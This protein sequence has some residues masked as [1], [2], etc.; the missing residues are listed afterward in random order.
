[1]AQTFEIT[2][3]EDDILD[4]LDDDDERISSIMFSEDRPSVSLGRA[5]H[6]IHALLTGTAT[7]SSGPLSFMI[8]GGQRLSGD[9][10]GGWV[11]A[12]SSTDV[13]NIKSKLP[14]PEALQKCYATDGLPDGVLYA[15]RL[16]K[17][18]AEYFLEVYRELIERI[19]EAVDEDQGMLAGLI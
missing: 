1:M 12:Y 7:K 14:S 17:D 10:N 13:A 4:E 19:A 2:F 3:V 5:W 8:G 15:D 11:C 18:G 9:A 16:D 6:I